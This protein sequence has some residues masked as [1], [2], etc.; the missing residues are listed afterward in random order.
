MLQRIQ[1]L[2]YI[3]CDFGA[4]YLTIRDTN[5]FYRGIRDVAT[6]AYYAEPMR[7]K[8]QTFDT[9]HTLICPEE[10]Q[11]GKKLK[12]LSTNFGRKFA[13]KPFEKYTSKEGIKWEPSRFYTLKENK[14]AE[15]LNYT[16]I[17]S[18][19]SILAAIYSLKT[20]WDKLIKTVA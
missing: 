16:L 3:H 15:R 4:L 13:N 17:S 19:Q 1:Y 10:R 18:V 20:L 8:S 9:F 14:E 12:H 7:I 2:D 6:R 11:S 5:W